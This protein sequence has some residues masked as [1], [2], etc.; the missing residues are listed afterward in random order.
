MFRAPGTPTITCCTYA[1]LFGQPPGTH[2][3]QGFVMLGGLL[4]GLGATLG[5]LVFGLLALVG[6]TVG[7]IL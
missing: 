7:S 6:G 5:S 1:A 2:N 3:L 4:F